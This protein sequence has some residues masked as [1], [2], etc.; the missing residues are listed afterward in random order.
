ML[1]I[2]LLL[3]L[4]NGTIVPSP[5]AYGAKPWIIIRLNKSLRDM[6]KLGWASIRCSSARL[7]NTS[8]NSSSYSKSAAGQW[9]SFS[10][11]V[12]CGICHVDAFGR[13]SLYAKRIEWRHHVN[14]IYFLEP[15]RQ[16]KAI[17]IYKVVEVR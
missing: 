3:S 8:Y 17:Y 4:I 13:S 6:I 15:S 1:F 14:T 5:N 16:H 9:Q 12:L 7:S 10:V 11:A 2:L